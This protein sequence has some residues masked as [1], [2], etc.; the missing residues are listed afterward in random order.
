MG[1]VHHVC[2]IPTDFDLSTFESRLETFDGEIQCVHTLMP[3]EVLERFRRE[4]VVGRI[5]LCRLYNRSRTTPGEPE[6]SWREM[7]YS[8]WIMERSS[9][10]ALHPSEKGRTQHTLD[11]LILVGLCR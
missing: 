2:G 10:L 7:C 8:P 3:N 9:R 4:I 1:P 11:S 5:D 6:R